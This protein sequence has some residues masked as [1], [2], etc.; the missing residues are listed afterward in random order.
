MDGFSFKRFVVRHDQCAMK[1]G[2][3]GVLLGAWAQ[4]GKRILDIGTGSGL[5]ALMMAQRFPDATIIG[6]DIEENAAKQ[7][8][9]NVEASVFYRQID[10][11]NVSLQEYNSIELFDSITCNP[12]FFE[13][14]LHC[15]DV[16]RDMARHTDTLPYSE[17]LTHCHR[18]LTNEGTLNLIIPTDSLL[19][20]EEESAYC[21]MFIV[22][23]VYIRTSE[24]KLPKRVLVTLSKQLKCPDYPITVDLM[25]GGKRSKW[26]SELTK[27]FYLS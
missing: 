18:L 10:I 7:A 15:H 23:K 11:E 20:I 19:R 13:E 17:L 3:D 22:R 2:T 12:P 26:Y 8:K 9:E 27:D 6:I 5:I 21:S 1:V 25:D 14:N 4:G 16:K 24:R